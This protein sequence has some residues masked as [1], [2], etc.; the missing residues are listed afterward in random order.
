MVLDPVSQA[1]ANQKATSTNT[2]PTT[3]TETDTTVTNVRNL[4]Q[5]YSQAW[6][7]GRPNG[8]PFSVQRKALAG[9]PRDSRTDHSAVN[10]ALTSSR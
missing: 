7:K 6:K 9:S 1:T 5:S 8:R 10:V 2:A 3:A 4:V